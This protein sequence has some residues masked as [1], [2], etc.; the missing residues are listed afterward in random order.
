MIEEVIFN[1]FEMSETYNK[2][3]CKHSSQFE[4]DPL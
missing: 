2:F 3:F 4:N 1:D